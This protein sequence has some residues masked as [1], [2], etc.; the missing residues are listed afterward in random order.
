M[1]GR[2]VSA[3]G[4]SE[5]LHAVN[6]QALALVIWPLSERGHAVPR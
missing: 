2:Y 5:K 1:R 3:E 6:G 4:V